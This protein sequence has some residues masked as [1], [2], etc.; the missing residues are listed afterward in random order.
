MGKAENHKIRLSAGEKRE[1]YKESEC[2][3]LTPPRVPSLPGK[4]IITINSWRK[5][6]TQREIKQV[7]TAG[8]KFP[9]MGRE[10]GKE[11]ATSCPC[12][13]EPAGAQNPVS[14]YS[15][16]ECMRNSPLEE[17]EISWETT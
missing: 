17:G 4:T 16:A 2:F 11:T 3:R 15:D 5:A 1:R 6:G 9:R 10:E 8:M 7:T 12:L 14:T 13:P